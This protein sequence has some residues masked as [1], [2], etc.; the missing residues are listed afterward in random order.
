MVCDL[1]SHRI[2]SATRR[3]LTHCSR[4][5]DLTDASDITSLPDSLGD[6]KK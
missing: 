3:L 1:V 4:Q 2:D 6:L 5:L